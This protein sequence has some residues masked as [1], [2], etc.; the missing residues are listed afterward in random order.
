M[1][2]A[3]HIKQC[4]RVLAILG[5]NKEVDIV[6][7]NCFWCFDI[8]LFLNRA[9]NQ[10]ATRLLSFWLPEDHTFLLL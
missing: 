7:L 3:S 6:P 2:T 8:R 1:T 5:D 10:M 9:G 4:P